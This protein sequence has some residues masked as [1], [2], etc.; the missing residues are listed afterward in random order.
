MCGCVCVSVKCLFC[1]VSVFVSVVSGLNYF[2]I[3]VVCV[4]ECFFLF[5]GV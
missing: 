5:C 1:V 2:V 4:R 3:V